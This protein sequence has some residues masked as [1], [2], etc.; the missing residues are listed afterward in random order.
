MAGLP[1]WEPELSVAIS[2]HCFAKIRVVLLLA[3]WGLGR[4]QKDLTVQPIWGIYPDLGL[5]LN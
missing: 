3:K 2:Y 5:D 4:E 1:F